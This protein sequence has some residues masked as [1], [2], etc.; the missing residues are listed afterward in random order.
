MS[1]GSFVGSLTGMQVLLDDSLTAA[2]GTEERHW[3]EVKQAMEV[4]DANKA[5]VYWSKC[6]SFVKEI[7]WLRFRLFT[8]VTVPI[9]R[10]VDSIAR[11][12][13]P[14]NITN[15]RSFDT[16]YCSVLYQTL[17]LKW[18]RS[19]ILWSNTLVLSGAIPMKKV[20][21]WWKLV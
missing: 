10:K 21:S 6:N 7:N 16:I 4:L 5:A 9:E 2:R 19:G 11:M 17:Q 15:I 3:N 8:K 20:F 14:E 12:K 18:S 1:N 13:R